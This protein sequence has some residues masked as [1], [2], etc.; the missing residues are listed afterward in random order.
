MQTN[1]R[2]YGTLIQ[3]RRILCFE[4]RYVLRRK[5]L[6]CVNGY[7]HAHNEIPSPARNRRVTTSHMF[8]QNNNDERTILFVVLYFNIIMRID[9]YKIIRRPVL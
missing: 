4:R 5:S 1:A 9:K 2:S 8:A 7:A 3:F 6:F